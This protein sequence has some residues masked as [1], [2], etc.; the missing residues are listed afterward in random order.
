MDCTFARLTP[1]NCD[2]NSTM[3]SE[4]ELTPEEDEPEP[5]VS[6]AVVA[7]RINEDRP[8]EVPG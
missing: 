3:G 8:A 4:A 5:R 7:D 1:V 2:S 6:I